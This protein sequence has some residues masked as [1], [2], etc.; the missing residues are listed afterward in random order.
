MSF[1]EPYVPADVFYYIRTLAPET[2]WAFYDKFLKTRDKVLQTFPQDCIK[3]TKALD[4]I[5]SSFDD[6]SQNTEKTASLITAWHDG[7]N[8]F[9]TTSLVA[10]AISKLDPENKLSAEQKDAMFV[11][12]V[13]ADI[14]N[15]LPYHNSLHYRKVLLHVIRMIVAHN[16]IFDGSENVLN[17]NSIVKLVIAACIHDLGHQGSSNIIDRKY[18]MAMTEKRSFSMAEPYLKSAGLADDILSDIRT[19]II[20]TDVSPFGDP[21]SPVNQMRSAYEYHFGMGAEEDDLEFS[22]ELKPLI[23]NDRLC[24][25]C[26]MLHE[27]DIMNSAGISY[28]MMRTES[29]A[30]SKEAGEDRAYPEDALLFLNKICKNVMLSDAASYLADANLDVILNTVMKDYKDGNKTYS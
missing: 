8:C 27:A 3:V 23:E 22:D 2:S 17:L 5:F 30:I 4:N 1:K 26:M 16:Y 21:I 14:P 19:M 9:S 20:T 12:G 6:V 25:L 29:V 11:A 24:L 28:D 15:D 7:K 13:L 10:Y 18:H